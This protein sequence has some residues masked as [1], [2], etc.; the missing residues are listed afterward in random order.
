MKILYLVEWESK[1]ESGVSIKV[2]AQ[3]NEW[4]KQGAIVH[5]VVLSPSLR[6]NGGKSV[7][8]GLGADTVEHSFSAGTFFGKI[9]KI[10][11][12]SKIASIVKTFAPEIIYY[13]QTSWNLGMGKIF[14]GPAKTVLEVNSN[15]LYEVGQA[16]KRLRKIY[17]KF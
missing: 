14:T 5:L 17:H 3:V 6:Q 16:G 7:F 1:I 10:K 13:R 8:D 4:R 9:S 2:K 11:Q 12:L 15:D